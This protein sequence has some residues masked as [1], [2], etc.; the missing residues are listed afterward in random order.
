[1]PN[2]IIEKFSVGSNVLLSFE[3]EDDPVFTSPVVCFSGQECQPGKIWVT[4]NDAVGDGVARFDRKNMKAIDKQNVPA[5]V[6]N[7]TLTQDPAS[8]HVWVT[9]FF[10]V[11]RFNPVTF[12]SLPE[13]SASILVGPDQY[14][15]FKLK[16]GLDGNLYALGINTG[17]ALAR[18]FKIVAIPGSESIS[19]GP[20][21]VLHASVTS[22]VEID[23]DEDNDCFWSFDVSDPLNKIT[24]WDRVTLSPTD[25]ALSSPL[26]LRSDRISF[27]SL[28]DK[29]WF[30][31][32]STAGIQYLYEISTAGVRGFTITFPISG[33]AQVKSIYARQKFIYAS[34]SDAV[35]PPGIRFVKGDPIT[36]LI[37]STAIVGRN[38]S[39]IG[40]NLDIFDMLI[41]E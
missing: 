18:I 14:E 10:S 6:G 15:I 3:S 9:D 4:F 7:S 28:N 33:V 8:E 13:Y 11:Y 5:F 22:S 1:M 23:Y 36:G 34:I 25:I 35:N 29:L 12:P 20:T 27:R 24:K 39:A 32:I 16:S 40:S 17:L 21:K 2:S 37:V 30:G 26:P 38:G 41:L 31:S 19:S